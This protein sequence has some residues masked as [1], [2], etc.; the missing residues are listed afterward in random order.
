MT[1]PDQ[2]DEDAPPRGFLEDIKVAA[3]FL[4]RLP[5]TLEGHIAPQRLT[6]AMRAFPV[7]GLI[8]G[9][10]GGAAYVVA[11]WLGLGVLAAGV[12][13]VGVMVLATGA[14]HEDGLADTAD[15]FGGGASL[16]DKLAIMRDSRLGTYG[17][18]VLVLSLLLKLALIVEIQ[19]P[20]AVLVAL[21]AA[22]ALSR[23]M[24]VGIMVRLPPARVEGLSADAGR[25]GVDVLVQALMI[26]SVT[27][28]LTLPLVPALLAILA[29]VLAAG[30]LGMLAR[31]Q[32]GGQTGD[33]LGA[34]QVVAELAV[35]AVVAAA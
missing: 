28:L 21:V 13:A 27:A 14:L 1:D 5:V 19:A 7:I 23:A 10:I 17:T 31:R 15:G 22:G 3:V 9:G 30:A 16:E 12:L 11:H 4:T 33:V 29:A 24:I 6:Q 25:P 18:L 26:A 32:I 20:W 2:H 34:A 8:V 35:L